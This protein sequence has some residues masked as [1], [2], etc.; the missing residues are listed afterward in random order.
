V[1]EVTAHYQLTSDNTAGI[2]PEALAALEQANSGV[3]PS[4]GDDRWTNSV[5]KQV[6]E[7]FE[8]DCAVFFCSNGTA[9]NA[10]ALAQL[11]QSFHSIVCYQH[12]HLQTDECGAPEFF[13]GGS[14]LLLI[15]GDSGKI[16]LAHAEMVITEQQP[17]HSHKPRAIS[18]TQ[19]T[20]LGTIYSADEIAA[21][22]ELGRRHNLT[23]HMDGA[24]FANAVASL[25]C[26]PKK[27]TWQA[28]VDVLCFG[29][30]KNGL[31]GA[32]LILFFNKELATDFEYRLKQAGQMQ[33]KTRFLAAQWHGLLVDDIWLR[34]AR[35]ANGMAQ[36]LAARL[37]SE[38]KITP[39]FPVEANAVF[40]RLDQP[41]GRGL[42]ERGWHLYQFVEPDIFRI[43]CSW[44]VTNSDLDRFISDV[45]CIQQSLS[46]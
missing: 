12:A 46:L 32:E 39:V 6:Q 13:T 24:R 1:N 37:Q 35:H 27:L 9:A 36:K 20:E 42:R 7:L 40:V 34:N 31:A 10:I 45:V 26:A 11:C 43:M 28:G 14:K 5:R 8:S 33:S 4:Y 23:L 25:G 22:A 15:G 38:A 2:C 41:T 44:S 21:F 19:A 17:L 29:G 30:T 3:A 16:G 18:I